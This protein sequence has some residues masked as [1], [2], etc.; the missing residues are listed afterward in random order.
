MTQRQLAKA[1]GVSEWSIRMAEYGKTMSPLTQE[2][3]ARALGKRRQTVFPE[4]AAS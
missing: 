1:A 2:K 3:I 4:E